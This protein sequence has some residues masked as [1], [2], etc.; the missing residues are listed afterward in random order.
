MTKLWRSAGGRTAF[1]SIHVNSFS[2]FALLVLFLKV[3]QPTCSL[4]PKYEAYYSVSLTRE[5]HKWLGKLSFPWYVSVGSVLCW[6]KPFCWPLREVL[7]IL[8][9]PISSASFCLFVSG[10]HVVVQPLYLILPLQ[11]LSAVSLLVLSFCLLYHEAY[12]KPKYRVSFP[13]LRKC[14]LCLRRRH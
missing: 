3:P 4:F 13:S 9:E 5:Y 11:N 8:E 7:R 6:C 12:I 2:W 1:G 14:S 10:D